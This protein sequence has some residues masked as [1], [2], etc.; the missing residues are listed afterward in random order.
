MIIQNEIAEKKT[1]RFSELD[2]GD[3]FSYDYPPTDILIKL[4]TDE[5][6]EDIDGQAIRAIYLY[7]GSAVDEF[8]SDNDA[9][10]PLTGKLII[11]G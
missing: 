4:A 9:V 10:Y 2:G 8:F 11:T 6:F 7:D 5:T 3:I 1:V